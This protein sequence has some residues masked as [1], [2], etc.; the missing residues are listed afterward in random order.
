[1][2]SLASK[3]QKLFN[4]QKYFELHDELEQWWVNFESCA[5][6]FSEYF[7]QIRLQAIIQLVVAMHHLV[8]NNFVGFEILLQKASFKLGN[9]ISSKEDA[10]K[11]IKEFLDKLSFYSKSGE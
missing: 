2:I 6:P 7:T 11:Q 4:E 9:S 3:L 8:N 5:N 1:M 10:L